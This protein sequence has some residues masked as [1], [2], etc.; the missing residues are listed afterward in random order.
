MKNNASYEAG[1]KYEYIATFG[2]FSRT[3]FF[4]KALRTSQ[5]NV[6]LENH[7]PKTNILRFVRIRNEYEEYFLG[8]KAA[9]A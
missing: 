1:N 3:F 5:I 7:F 6:I 2:L 4:V 9:G 8:V